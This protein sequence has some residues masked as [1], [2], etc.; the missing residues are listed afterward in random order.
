MKK[1]LIRMKLLFSIK[2]IAFWA[3]IVLIL[4]FVLFPAYWMVSSS[5]KP[6]GEIF[7]A[8]PSYVPTDITFSHY[9]KVLSRSYFPRYFLN[10]LIVALS[11]VSL[12]LVVSI[13]AAYSFAR[14]R[15]KAAGALS[16]S[17]LLSQMFPVAVIL[18]P[19]YILMSKL[20][21]YDTYLSLILAYLV[22][23]L[24]LSVWLLMGI[25]KTIPQELEESAMLD[26]CSRLQALARITLPLSASG[27]AAVAIYL[28]MLAW[29]EFMLALTLTSSQEMRTFPVGLV[30]FFEQYGL[31]FDLLFAAGTL[32]S[33]PVIVLFFFIQKYFVKGLI[34]GAVKG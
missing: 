13:S 10:S 14:Y 24:P 4:T 19:L 20:N 21:L 15:F 5:L 8:P 30:T 1:N 22:F 11:T 12:A 16:A 26:G 2:R 23:A 34:A 17:F 9:K 32:G 31:Q 27:I 3:A 33:L 18:I 29:N 7:S 6:T 25:F 28:F